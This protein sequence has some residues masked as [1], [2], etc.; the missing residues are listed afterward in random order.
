MDNGV[1]EGCNWKIAQRIEIGRPSELR[2][3]A[4]KQNGVV[5]TTWIG[6]NCIQVAID[7]LTFDNASSPFT[8][9][10]DPSAE[11]TADNYTLKIPTALRD[12]SGNMMQ[13]NFTWCFTSKIQTS[14]CDFLGN[15]IS[16]NSKVVGYNPERVSY[17]S[18]GYARAICS[19]E[20]RLC[21]N[22][23][24]AGSYPLDSCEIKDVP[25]DN[26]YDWRPYRIKLWEGDTAKR[27]K[28]IYFG[29]SG[30]QY[31]IMRTRDKNDLAKDVPRLS[32]KDGSPVAYHGPTDGFTIYCD[33]QVD[34]CEKYEAD[35]N[36]IEYL[37]TGQ[38]GAP[39]M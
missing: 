39:C 35:T 4:R 9:T 6:G 14:T 13:S 33:S 3:R 22:G 23:K 12:L 1:D 29:V 27:Y 25:R 37:M 19:T 31:F 17:A 26:P 32:Y 8:L 16:H 34:T 5:T 18:N 10:I 2:A 24:L 38:C 11:Y 36:L 30:P 20:N 15:I 28:G 7:S 21:N